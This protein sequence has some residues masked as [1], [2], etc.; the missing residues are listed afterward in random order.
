MS[1][2]I[3]AALASALLQSLW[4]GAALGLIAAALFALLARR[5]AALRHA[6]GMVVLVAMAVAPLLTFVTMI[7]APSDRVA[8]DLA[9][10]PAGVPLPPLAILSGTTAVGVPLWLGWLWIAGVALMAARLA[11]GWAMLRRL[12]TRAFES[13]PPA[14]QARADS[15]RRTLGIRRQVAIRLL[16]DSV[17]PC[18][19]RALRPV[20]WLPVSIL[21]RL[22][23][24]Q[25][26][27]LIAHELAHI[28]RLDWIWNG[29]QC[30]VETLLF[31][32]PAVWWL[33][34][35]IRAERENA[36]D[37]LAVAACG[38]PI[39]LAE[40]LSRLERLRMPGFRF[41]LPANGGLLMNRIKRLLSPEAP[42]TLRWGVPLGLIALVGTGVVL[43][44][45]AGPAGAR[46]R[47]GMSFWGRLVGNTMEIHD[48]VDGRQRLYKRSTD[49]HGRTYESYE[50]D[51]R[52]APIDA[53]VRRWV[54][55]AQIVPPPPLPPE[56]PLPPPPFI[57]TA[58]YQAAATAVSS[59]PR[60]IK[61]IGQPVS[62]L[63]TKGPSYLDDN[64]AD[65]TI[66]LWGPKG[67]A[68]LHAVGTRK[69]DAWEF[70][71]LEVR[72]ETGVGFDLA[73]P[74]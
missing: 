3:E 49:I 2:A 32:H 5:S 67:E 56:P 37:D 10:R 21:T 34:R 45:Q 58:A 40:A 17:L 18:T 20:I 31:Y 64:R 1:Q 63:G 65:M 14:W 13:L 39:V 48:T 54:H 23:P 68:R 38:D 53:G 51:G 6:L 57:E 35:R 72:P 70:Q 9:I 29:L 8:G 25:I 41:A 15:L 26:E 69:G 27:A 55:D 74:R 73:T 7:G 43:A 30:A 50:V 36:C 33:S 42:P 59:D 44:G 16:H 12:D 28:R 62:V 11:G 24:E 71:Q 46:A 61:A 19:A 22:S 52:P 47:D 4:Q 60:L 66:A